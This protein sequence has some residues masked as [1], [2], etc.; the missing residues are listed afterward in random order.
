M[1]C[2]SRG[3]KTTEPC[4]PGPAPVNRSASLGREKQKMT[5][6]TSGPT[7]RGLSPSADLQLSLESRLQARLE[8]IGSPLYGLKW[9]RWDMLSG[10]PIC[11]LRGSGRRTLDSGS[12][13][14]GWLTP[15]TPTGGGQAVRKTPSGGLRKLEDQAALV[16]WPTPCERDS[17][18]HRN[19]TANRNPE[20]KRGHPGNTLTDAATLAGVAHPANVAREAGGTPEQ[21]LE[22]KRKAVKRG[23]KLGVSLTS[24]SL[25]AQTLGS[26]ATGSPAQTA[27]GG[28]L[29]P[30]HSRWLMGY[31]AEWD[32]CAAT[33]TPSSPK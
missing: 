29:N 28:Q 18:S 15:K 1:R 33:A 13:S 12:T 9:K 10:P 3:G 22:R 16:G 17:A 14:E 32:D 6:D 24:L 11:A 5:I 20:S 26:S 27:S 8:G 2:A 19:S 31:P 4:G 25:Q 23:A 7:G 30:A 21:F